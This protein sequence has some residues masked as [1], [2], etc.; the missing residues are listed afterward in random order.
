M[1]VITFG[2]M[3]ELTNRYKAIIKSPHKDLRLANMLDD[4]RQAYGIPLLR[5]NQF[6]HNNPYLMQMYRTVSFSREFMGGDT[7][8]GY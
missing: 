2:E 6:E 8:V 1:K 3:K 5:N 4:M 7:V